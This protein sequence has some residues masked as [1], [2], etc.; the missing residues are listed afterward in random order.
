MHIIFHRI[1]TDN[2]LMSPET[3]SSN[4]MK[5][6]VASVMRQLSE[7]GKNLT[8]AYDY[9][10]LK[11][12]GQ[13][14]LITA[15]QSK[16]AFHVIVPYTRGDQQHLFEFIGTGENQLNPQSFGSNI[17][18]LYR[19]NWGVSGQLSDVHVFNIVCGD[20]KDPAHSDHCAS[21]AH[22]LPNMIK[23]RINK[24]EDRLSTHKTA[25]MTPV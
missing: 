4:P 25:G 23:E 17:L 6:M 13:H 8:H 9:D 5:R 22:L 18:I 10:L 7:G 16:E 2:I 15:L 24:H 14:S 19:S 1:A 20:K 12:I 11:P 21:A 3:H